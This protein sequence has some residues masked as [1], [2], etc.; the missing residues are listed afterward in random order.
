MLDKE[1]AKLKDDD[2]KKVH[3]RAKRLQTRKKN[4]I[5]TNEENTHQKVMETKDKMRYL[6]EFRFQNKV[7]HNQE[8]MQFCNTM[9]TWSHSGYKKQVPRESASMLNK[10]DDK[11]KKN[12]DLY[13]KTY[14]DYRRGVNTSVHF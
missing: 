14:I 6:K 2:M 5:M 12:N 8:R 9:D 7:K 4:E 13:D 1:L 11:L 10:L 3:M